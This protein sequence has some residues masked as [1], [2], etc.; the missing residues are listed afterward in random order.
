MTDIIYKQHAAGE[1]S[2][3]TNQHTHKKIKIKKKTVLVNDLRG[4]AINGLFCAD[5]LRPLDLAPPPH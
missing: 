4:M 5:V 3:S 1:I 2:Q